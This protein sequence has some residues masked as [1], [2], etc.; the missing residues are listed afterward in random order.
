MSYYFSTNTK[1]TFD[2]TIDKV[3]ALLKQEGFGI[4]TEIDMKQTLKNK[5]DVDIKKY[6]ILGACNPPFAY[7]ALQA[8]NKIGTMLPCNFIVQELEPN[9]IEVSCINPMVSMQAV[10]NETLKDVAQEVSSKLEN[11]IK[12]LNNEA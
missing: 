11:V 1:G 12:N 8:E 9:Q 6:K 2:E 10:G 5:L 4:L 7:K 3:T